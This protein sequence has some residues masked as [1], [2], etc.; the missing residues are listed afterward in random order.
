MPMTEMIVM[1]AITAALLL[2]FIHIVRLITAVLLHKTIRRA[3]DRDPEKADEMISRL[4]SPSSGADDD[5]FS[6][7]LIAVGIAMIAASVVVNDPSWIHY[8]VA[9]ALF[10]LVVGTALWLRQ[11]IQRRTQRAGRQ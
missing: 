1:V 3:I 9:A 7:I 5:R 2:A 6:T 8:G 4:G 10:P 11:F